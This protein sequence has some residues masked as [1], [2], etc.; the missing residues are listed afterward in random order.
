MKRIIVGTIFA[1]LLMST[2]SHA[3]EKLL[4][5]DILE[6]KEVEIM[7]RF[8]YVHQSINGDYEPHAP[9]SRKTTNDVSWLTCVLDVGL[10][11]GFQMGA[12]IPYAF[13]DE[14]ETRFYVPGETTDFET[15]GFGDL[16]LR[17]RYQ[18]FSERDKPFTL[19]GGLNV[20]LETA[21]E[22]DWGLGATHIS[23]YVALSSTI[24]QDIRPYA[25][26]RATIRNHGQA[27]THAVT[28]GMEKEL[29]ERVGLDAS[30]EIDLHTSSDRFSGYESYWFMLDTYIRICRDFYVIP[31]V[32]FITDTSYKN[33]ELDIHWHQSRTTQVTL[34]LY[35]L[36]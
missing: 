36:F 13:S 10:G 7:A 17:T 11:H 33:K 35:Y 31:G 21:S 25:I 18:V 34:A 15:D 27:D 29:N 12:A 26:Y 2:T 19:V 22:D 8:S 23:P 9:L 14:A 1:M 5:T 3:E 24:A 28:V 16:S 6:Q 20:K 4:I 32:R 30:F